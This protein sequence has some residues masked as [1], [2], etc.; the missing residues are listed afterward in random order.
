MLNGHSMMVGDCTC[1]MGWHIKAIGWSANAEY[2]YNDVS[3]RLLK[4][5]Y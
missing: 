1:N 2:L 5:S 4:I 3:W